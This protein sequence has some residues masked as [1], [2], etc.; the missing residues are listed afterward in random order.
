VSINDDISHHIYILIH[1]ISLEP[2]PTIKMN[3]YNQCSDFKLINQG[4]Y[5]TNTRWN[6]EPDDEINVSSMAGAIFTSIVAVF[7]GGL[8]YQL[9]RKPIKSDGQLES[10][11]TLLFITWKSEGY[12]ELCARVCLIE[13]D[14]Q[15]RWDGYKS[16]DYYQR[17]DNQFSTYTGPIKDTWLIHDG[18]VLMTRLDLDLTQ[19]NGV[20]NITISEGVKDEH[21]KMPKLIIPER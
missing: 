21:T 7:E 16:E 1:T 12:K 9:Q 17:Y 5:S 2:Q 11:S 8:T 3:I 10:T 20:L 19:R 15:I 6:K 14:K 13:Y 18:T 4:C